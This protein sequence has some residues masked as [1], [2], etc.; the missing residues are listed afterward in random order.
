MRFVGVTGHGAQV[1]A[2]HRRSLK[3]FDFGSVLLPYNFVMMQND[4]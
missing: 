3:R 4:Y 2:T 1:A